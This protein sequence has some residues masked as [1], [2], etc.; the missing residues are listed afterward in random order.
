MSDSVGVSGAES[1]DAGR[2][3]SGGTIVIGPGAR[4]LSGIGYHTASVAKALQADG[5]PTAAML[6]R[7][8]CPQWIYPGRARVGTFGSEVLDLDGV[9][10]YEGLDWYWGPQMLAARRFMQMRRPRTVLFQWWTAVTAHTYLQLAAL[11]RRLGARVVFEMHE[12]TDVGEAAIPFVSA[13]ASAMMRRLAPLIDGVVLHSE[14]DR[15]SMAVAFPEL[16]TRPSAVIFPGPLGRE[17]SLGTVAPRNRDD[18]RVRF[19]YFGVI[20]AYKGIDELADAFVSLASRVGAVHLR[21][22]GEVWVEAGPALAR[23]RT[24]DPDRWTIEEG[25]VADEAV[26]GLFEQADVVVAP[27]RRAS[28][29]GPINLTMAAGLPLVTTRVPA[30]VEACRDYGGVELARSGDAADLDGAME[31]SLLLV[32]RRYPNPHSWADNARRSRALFAGLGA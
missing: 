27:Y 19:L 3:V 10:T 6:I 4:F 31:R 5:E 9:T 21:V 30:L 29:S 7:Q 26:P 18:G 25:F 17:G 28:A 14:S 20:R 16:M 1:I 24:L 8:L 11:A 23:I 22:V 12:T 13:Y 2:P 15:A 32:G